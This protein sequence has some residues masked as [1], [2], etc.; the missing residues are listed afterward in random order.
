MKRATQNRLYHLVPAIIWSLALVGSLVPVILQIANHQLS[1]TD[2]YYWGYLV[3]SVVL[4]CIV[5]IGRIQRHATSEEECF[6]IALLL[7][8]ASYWLPPV[9]FLIPVFCGYL[10][11]HNLFSFRSAAAAL[12]GVATVAIWAT[13]LILCACIDNPWAAFFAIENAWG[14][15]PT[16]AFLFAWSSSTIARQILRVR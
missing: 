13:I 16:G 5:I 10:I 12:I 6:Q 9:L 3:T 8:I 15:I 4:T 7:G 14:W 1:I 2:N 11:Y